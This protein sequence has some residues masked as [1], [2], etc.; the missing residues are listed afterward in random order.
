MSVKKKRILFLSYWSL[1]EPLNA[2]A[3]FPYLQLL[4]D[5][6]DVEEIHFVTLETAQGALPDVEF[7][8]PRV[9]HIALSSPVRWPPLFGKMLLF[10]WGILFLCRFVRRS[11][12]DLVI[13]KAALA[14]AMADIV[15]SMTGVPYNVES[16]EPH[17]EYMYE[18]GVWS[19][20]SLR[21]RFMRSMERRQM[22]R[23]RYV[24][25]VTWNHHADLLEQGLEKER[26]RVIPS[27]TDLSVFGPSEQ[28]SAH[29]RARLD[30]PPTSTVGIYVGKFG[31]L[32]YEEEAFTIFRRAFDHFPDL[33][34]VVLSIMPRQAILDH[35]VRA[36]IPMERF[37]TYTAAHTE[38][39]GYLAMADLAFSTIKPARINKYQSPVKNGEYWACGLPILMTDEVSDEH[40]L[41]RQGI[42]GRVYKHDLSDLDEAL[43]GIAVILAQPGHRNQ[44]RA[45]AERYR[46]LDIA[47]K[48]YDDLI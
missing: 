42:G 4:A 37:R 22:R 15:A 6:S 17:S 36:G 25:T 43:E 2:S 41:M 47:R 32:Y 8:I 14:G 18:C 16:F 7:E 26:V 1:R 40:R 33:Y 21:Y 46:S 10:T 30:I 45:L 38:V 20:N 23:A 44:I 27:I 39:P 11:K 19:R 5:R 13:A 3:V 12:I 48:A 35:A 24:V 34:I 31:G 28:Y 9:K 29:L